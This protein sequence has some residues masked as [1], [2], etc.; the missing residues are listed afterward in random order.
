MLD[1]LLDLIKQHAGTAIVDNPAIPNQHNE[2]AIQA[3]G[4][5][6]MDGLKNMIAQGKT[7]DIVNLFQH[8]GS[9]I[10]A[11]PATQQITGNFVQTLN[12]KASPSRAAGDGLQDPLD[13]K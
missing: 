5:S 11:Q 3:A 12:I 4:S 2:A 10:A 9:D 6:I 7:G 8:G 13:I 1:N